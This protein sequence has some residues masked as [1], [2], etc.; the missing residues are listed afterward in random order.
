MPKRR[1]FMSGGAQGLRLQPRAVSDM[2]SR[3]A[4]PTPMSTWDRI[5]NFAKQHK[6]VSRG[7]KAV[8]G[9]VGDKYAP[10]FNAGSELASSYGYGRK[11]RGRRQIGGS[12][13]VV[14]F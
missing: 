12:S 13:K 11:R 2:M 9:M 10:L 5:K 7:L 3:P 1:S 4:V 6:L 8:S 14:R